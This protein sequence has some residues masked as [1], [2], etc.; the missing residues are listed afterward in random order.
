[1]TD[2]YLVLLDTDKIKDYVFATGRLKEIRGAS[3]LLDHLN[4]E[5]VSEKATSH[6]GKPIFAAGGAA[7]VVFEDEVSA[8]EFAQ[9]VEKDYLDR[10]HFA[11]VTSVVIKLSKDIPFFELAKKAAYQLRRKKMRGRLPS[12]ILPRPLFYRCQRCGSFAVEYEF[13]YPEKTFICKV[14]REKQSVAKAEIQNGAG[15]DILAENRLVARAKENFD[16]WHNANFPGELEDFH[17]LSSPSNYIGLIY[18]DGNGVGNIIQNQ[19]KTIEEMQ[20]FSEI[21]DNAVYD[22]IIIALDSIGAVKNDIIPIIPILIGGD[23]LIVLIA[24]Q[25]AFDFANIL[26]TNFKK[27][28]EDSSTQVI[29]E[30]P[31]LHYF[32][33]QPLDVSMSAGLVLAKINHPIRALEQ[34]AG[35]LLISAK[36][37]T[38]NCQESYGN[39]GAFDFQVV[40]TATSSPLLIT[41]DEE[42]QLDNVTFAT[43]RPYLCQRVVDLD[44]PTWQD[45]KE[46]VQM[47]KKCGFPKNKLHEWQSLLYLPPQQAAMEIN[48]L[49]KRLSDEH[50]EVID[51]ISTK[52]RMGDS[53][54]MFFMD[55]LNLP[56]KRSPYP[57]LEEIYEFIQ[58]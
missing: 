58:E 24:S 48:F 18:A 44:V 38:R 12:E 54:Q 19:I 27:I 6:G 1:M 9:A 40:K 30:N 43:A 11:S 32:N 51:Q 52:L 4:K 17:N 42:F 16:V 36:K 37:L 34:L 35:E 15:L 53:N 57:D 8:I 50:Q 55:P 28:V 39:Q 45:L 14:C 3:A 20:V 46:S 31:D 13:Q 10:T 7:M 21:L 23:D 33:G 47:L 26:C 5:M 41:R 2:Q 56:Q 29:M 25:Y 22:S 49:M